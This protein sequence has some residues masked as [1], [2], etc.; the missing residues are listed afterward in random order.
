M[1]LREQLSQAQRDLDLARERTPKQGV[2]DEL[3]NAEIVLL[4][5]LLAP[6]RDGANRQ[7]GA[8]A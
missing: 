5:R 8:T 7:S 4:E 2:A 6:D 3:D 1:R